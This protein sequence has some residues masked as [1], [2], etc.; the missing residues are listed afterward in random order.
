MEPSQG[1]GRPGVAT[2]VHPEPSRREAKTPT[3]IRADERCPLRYYPIHPLAPR[4][5]IPIRYC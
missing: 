4:R 5:R 2:S 1:P 3:T